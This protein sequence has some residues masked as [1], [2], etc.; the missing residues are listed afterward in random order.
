[1]NV[2][3]YFLT[4]KLK[5]KILHWYGQKEPEIVKCTQF[6]VF[7]DEKPLKAKKTNIFMY[8]KL[9]IVL[10][11][12]VEKK[13]AE[14]KKDLCQTCYINQTQTPWEVYFMD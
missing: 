5:K 6:N 11:N 13:F 1:M 3:S 8:F 10:E 12:V 2:L 7:V 4:K 9:Q 14:S